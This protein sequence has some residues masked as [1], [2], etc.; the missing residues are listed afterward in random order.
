MLGLSVIKTQLNA[1]VKERSIF[2]ALF[3]NG[4]R[5]YGHMRH[6]C[7]ETLPSKE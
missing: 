1:R 3:R 6:L 4:I 5:I 7:F 2:I